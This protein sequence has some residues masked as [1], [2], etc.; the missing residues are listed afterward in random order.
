[1]PFISTI[2][3]ISNLQ[4]LSLDLSKCYK[5]ELKE[6]PEALQCLLSHQGLENLNL[7]FK[8]CNQFANEAEEALDKIHK[9]LIPNTS[10]LK[11]V[12]LDFTECKFTQENLEILNEIPKENGELNI[13]IITK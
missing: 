1:M 6:I 12:K 5:L 3:K 9:S 4:S 11:E 10:S 8:G 7:S 2:A 13:M